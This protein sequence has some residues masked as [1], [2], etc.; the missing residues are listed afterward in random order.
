MFDAELLKRLNRCRYTG[1]E[2]RKKH[3][4]G[5]VVTMFECSATRRVRVIAYDATGEPVAGLIVNPYN[6]VRT[7]TIEGIYTTASHRRQGYAKQL[8]VVARVTL[9]TVQHN[10]NLTADGK[11][12]RD[13]V[14]GLK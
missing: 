5:R 4:F 3:Q 7:Y 8:L 14:E 1:L 11:A 13:S 10:G 12:W 2:Y 6:R 9:G